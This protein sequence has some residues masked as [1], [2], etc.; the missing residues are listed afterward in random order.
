MAAAGCSHSKAAPTAPP[1]SSSN[2]LQVAG[3]VVGVGRNAQ[4]KATL[5]TADVTKS[6]TW[7]SSD[8]SVLTVSDTGMVGGV[9]DGTAV[10]TASYGGLTAAKAVTTQRCI[11]WSIS[12]P[13]VIWLGQSVTWQTDGYDSCVVH[14]SGASASFSSSDTSVVT[15]D[16][17]TPASSVTV[18]G[19]GPGVATL[20]ASNPAT[21]LKNATASG[22]VTVLDSV[23]PP[24]ERVDIE[25]TSGSLAWG[26]VLGASKALEATAHWTTPITWNE[27]VTSS[28]I[29]ST[30][31]PG[32][33]AISPNGVVTGVK[34]GTATISAVYDGVTATAT[35]PVGSD[36]DTLTTSF[37]DLHADVDPFGRDRFNA[38]VE[39]S[40]TLASSATGSVRLRLWDQATGTSFVSYNNV[41]L[42]GTGSSVIG[43]AIVTV[44]PTITS[45]CGTLSLVPTSLAI[46]LGCKPAHVT[47]P[48][49][50]RR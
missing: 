4:F 48:S 35:V 39:Y 22:T 14:W 11:S 41:A 26:L 3:G 13:K 8:E 7:S 6:A 45:M 43:G 29:W 32:V 10:V 27:D 47:G 23:R 46:E 33:V 1:T 37:I 20:H 16:R 44:P 38:R 18:T 9:G 17:A 30:S 42:K 5:D 31:D 24:P 49:L 2:S 21:G 19:V 40:F 12:G 25:A 34:S 28:V 36:H 50:L 15:V